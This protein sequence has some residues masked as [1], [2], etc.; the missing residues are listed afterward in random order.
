[1]AGEPK[2]RNNHKLPRWF[3]AGFLPI[4][5]FRYL[6][7]LSKW[8]PANLTGTKFSLDIFAQIHFVY[9]STAFW[10]SLP[11]ATFAI[12]PPAPFHSLKRHYLKHFLLEK[13]LE[14]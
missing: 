4:S 7:S 3:R 2:T 12:R 14:G 8:L 9:R 10:N 13:W 11:L 5:L 1:M 6:E